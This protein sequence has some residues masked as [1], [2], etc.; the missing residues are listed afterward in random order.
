MYCISIR[1]RTVQ[2]STVVSREAESDG[3]TQGQGYLGNF[4]CVICFVQSTPGFQECDEK[5]V[6]TWMA[7]NAEDWG[8]Q[9][10]NDDE[11]VTSVQEKSDPIDDETDKNE[12][13]NESSKDPLSAGV[14]SALETAMQWNVKQSE[15]CPTQ[16]MLLKSIR[17]LAAKKQRYTMVQ[18]KI[19]DYFPQ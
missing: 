2:C 3:K 15:C 7:F 12:A 6:E 5:G 1:F 18:R 13:N 16:L 10:V 8:F 9:M 17:D 19:S 11:I 14:F 4:S